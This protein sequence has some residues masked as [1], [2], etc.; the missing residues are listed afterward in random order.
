[1]AAAGGGE[2]SVQVP[3]S[4][5]AR[6][7]QLEWEHWHRQ[8]SEWQALWEQYK[9]YWTQ[10]WLQQEQQAAEQAAGAAAVH[11]PQPQQ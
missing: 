7:H 8:Y 2:G 3:A 11:S 4:L 10:L 1:M 9:G 6:Y 5:L